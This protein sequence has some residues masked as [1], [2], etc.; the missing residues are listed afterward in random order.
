MKNIKLIISMILLLVLSPIISI[1][2]NAAPEDYTYMLDYA[3]LL[4]DDEEAYLENELESIGNY[5]NSSVVILTVD[6]LEGKTAT[7]YADDYFDYNG[8][9]D[10]G[11]L[12]LI[13]MENRDWAIS[14]KGDSIYVFSDARQEN[15]IDSMRSSLKDN[16]FNSAFITFTE[17]CDQYYNEPEETS[18][19][20]GNLLIALIIGVIIGGITTF[21]FL[22]QL[23]TVEFQKTADNYVKANSLKVTRRNDLFLYSTETKTERE[24][25]SGSGS[26]THTSSSGSS[27]GGSSGK[28]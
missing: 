1:T 22:S 2:A 25:S 12:F 11:I 28:F 23:Q 7:A 18:S 16:D 14:T 17:L 27:H 15:M 26:S 19:G 13:S 8:Y 9:G 10:N 6:S 24:S 3:D 5:N 20:G 4:S 21:I